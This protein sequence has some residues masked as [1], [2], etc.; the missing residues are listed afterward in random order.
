MAYHPRS[1]GC[2]KRA[3]ISQLR[4]RIATAREG[5]QK[6]LDL[7]PGNV[8]LVNP[9]DHPHSPDDLV[10]DKQ[11]PADP[12]PSLYVPNP[13]L[14]VDSSRDNIG[15]PVQRSPTHP[16]NY[17]GQGS[18]LGYVHAASSQQSQSSFLTLS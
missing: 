5:I 3:S 17:I 12:L 10:Q 11:R 18:G 16:S 9:H 2:S 14:Q 8:N 13:T 4:E 6:F 7:V 1:H 15:L